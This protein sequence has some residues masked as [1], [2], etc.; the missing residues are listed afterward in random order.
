MLFRSEVG[1]KYHVSGLKELARFKFELA[2][3]KFWDDEMFAEAAAHAF[4]T[5][6][7]KDQGLRRI[8]CK[9]ISEHMGLLKR[10]GVAGLLRECNGVAFG[11]LME[12]AEKCGW[13]N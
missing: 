1:D 12:K 3:A 6:P 2:C 10:E 11:L 7:E 13:L 4:S 5:T 8:V 9:T